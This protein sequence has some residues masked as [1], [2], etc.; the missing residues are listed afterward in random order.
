M[1]WI[2]ILPAGEFDNLK[3][4][5]K[6]HDDHKIHIWTD[7]HHILAH[8]LDTII[9]D[10]ISKNSK[11]TIS[12]YQLIAQLKDEFYHNYQLKNQTKTFD[13]NAKQFL[14]DKQFSKQ[15]EIAAW[16]SD[17]KLRWQ[18]EIAAIKNIQQMMSF[19]MMLLMKKIFFIANTIMN[20]IYKI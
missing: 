5:A 18:T 17:S 15:T 6:Y 9:F 1:I 20:N 10:N 7:Y 16:I 12:D 13:D 8:R 11:P 3:L 19:Y 4:W 14:I 2:G